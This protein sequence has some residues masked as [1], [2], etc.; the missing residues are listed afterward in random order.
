M[1]LTHLSLQR[2]T[3]PK[4]TDRL[5]A[6]SVQDATH[7]AGPARTRRRRRPRIATSLALTLVALAA[8]AFLGTY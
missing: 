1:T 3:G 4:F 5:L 6:Y 8:L 2:V 7:S